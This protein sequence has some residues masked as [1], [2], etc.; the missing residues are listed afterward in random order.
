M[1]KIR[2]LFYLVDIKK[3]SPLVCFDEI[4]DY[5]FD[6]ITKSSGKCRPSESSV[7]LEPF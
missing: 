5:C 4:I 6:E 3:R 1:P 2:T 7:V